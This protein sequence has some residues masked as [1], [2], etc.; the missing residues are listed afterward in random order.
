MVDTPG[1]SFGGKDPQSW[2]NDIPQDQVVRAATHL[3]TRISNDTTLKQ[4]FITEAKTNRQITDMLP[5][6]T[7]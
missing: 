2:V 7:S 4:R 5:Q 3:L 1:M 6:L